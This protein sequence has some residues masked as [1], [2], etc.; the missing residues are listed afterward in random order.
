MKSNCASRSSTNENC[1]PLWFR[2]PA[3]RRDACNT[4]CL[5]G[6]AIPRGV[7]VLCFDDFRAAG[8]GIVRERLSARRTLRTQLDLHAFL[9]QLIRAAVYQ[10]HADA[11]GGPEE[12]PDDVSRRPQ[13]Q[14][15]AHA[16]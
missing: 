11:N 15:P 6:R 12:A 8:R 14:A 7:D 16:D 2:R 4:S 5:L 13:V 9:G 10:V 3:C 1:E